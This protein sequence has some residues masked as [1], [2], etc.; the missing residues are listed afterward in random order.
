MLLVFVV[1]TVGCMFTCRL[2]SFPRSGVGLAP[3]AGVRCCATSTSLALS[4]FSCPTFSSH[5]SGKGNGFDRIC[6][7]EAPNPWKD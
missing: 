2:I 6:R 7:I 3:L 5:P 1:C 4:N